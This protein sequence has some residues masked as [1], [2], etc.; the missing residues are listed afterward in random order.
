[1]NQNKIS[2]WLRGEKEKFLPMTAKQRLE[3]IWDYYRWWILAFVILLALVLSVVD[4]GLYRHRRVLISGMFINSSTS[5]AGY[6]FVDDDYWE[7]CGADRN[8]RTE[9]VEAELLS[10]NLSQSTSAEANALMAVDAMIAVGDLDYIICD[11][12]AAEYYGRLDYCVEL[13]SRLEEGK[14][15][16]LQTQGGFTAVDLTGSR[17][18]REFGLSEEPSYILF[19][20]TAPDWERCEAFLRY[21]FE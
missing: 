2:R 3:Y 10:Y 21:I 13:S 19:P 16:L 6:A 5:E 9:L 18:E 11:S 15:K 4:S 14:W 17:L 7:Y 12:T 1:M 20:Q 8:T